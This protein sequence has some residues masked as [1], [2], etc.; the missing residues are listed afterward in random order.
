MADTEHSWPE[1]FLSDVWAGLSSQPKTLPS[2]YFYD[3]KG[4]ALFDDI[5]E[6][7][8]YYLTRTEN[9]LL[10]S[11]A[12]EIAEVVGEHA[13][14]VEY[15]AGGLHKIRLLLPKLNAVS[16]FVPIDVS[17][18]FL[19]SA[20]EALQAEYPSVTVEP[21]VGN[22]LALDLDTELPAASGRR[23]GFF[24]GSTLG[25]LDDEDI[26]H[27][28]KSARTQ[29]GQGSGFLLGVDTNHDPGSLIPAYDDAAGTTAAFNLNIL[30]RINRQLAGGFD[31]NTFEHEARWNA[32]ASRIEM[33]LR[34][35]KDQTVLVAGRQF[36]FESG[37][38]I[39]TENSRKFSDAQLQNLLTNTGWT[40]A[41]VW[42]SPNCRVS[43][44]YLQ[45]S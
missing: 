7:P 30:E 41:N 12:G 37:E 11:A 40:L 6:L 38:T 20:A 24:P 5:T 10:Q 28:F 33:H 8:E 17:G 3:D 19:F 44:F 34:S 43:L 25:N 39:H 29:L 18:P 31:L 26:V 14:I 36:R 27:F 4:S 22:F 23:V 35:V 2:Q 42:R 21:R 9:A 13:C 45:A 15:G 1:P 16:A 32:A